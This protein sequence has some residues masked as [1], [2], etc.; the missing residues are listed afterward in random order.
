MTGVACA[1]TSVSAGGELSASFSA[2]KSVRLMPRALA[3]R[4]STAMVGFERLRSTSESIDFETPER[5]ERSSSDRFCARRSSC[6]RV[7]TAGGPSAR[8]IGLGACA[9][10]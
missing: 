6:S 2:R 5:L 8:V 9:M 10:G 7:P 4:Q 1:E 3:S